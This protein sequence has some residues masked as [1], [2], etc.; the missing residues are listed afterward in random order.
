MEW[1]NEPAK[2]SSDGIDLN[3]TA[4]ASTDFWRVTGEG[5]DAIRDNGHLYGE[6]IADDFDLSVDVQGNFKDQYDQAGVMVRV[7]DRQWF[8]TGVEFL[9]GR[10]RFSTVVTND[11]SN[12]MIAELLVTFRQLSIRVEY[13]GN[14]VEVHRAVDGGPEEF[15]SH[16][17]LPRQR[18]KF[19]GVMCAAP[20]GNGSDVTFRNLLLTPVW[21]S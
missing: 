17:Y 14:A 7:S 10:P 1:L 18:D 21:P 3:V 11:Y 16:V 9:N 20:K 4:D 13:R 12:W 8:K 15:A 6:R 19:V 5:F 2:W